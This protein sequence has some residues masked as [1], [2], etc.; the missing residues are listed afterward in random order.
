MKQPREST[1]LKL[2]LK[3][4]KHDSKQKHLG[5]KI[6]QA[7]IKINVPFASEFKGMDYPLSSPHP[8]SKVLFFFMKMIFFFIYLGSPASCF[9]HL[10]A[11]SVYHT[12]F[13]HQISQDLKKTIVKHLLFLPVLFQETP[14]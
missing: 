9:L 13:A 2:H 12:G 3:P 4:H 7:H 8:D 10:E 14:F 1:P 6:L 11:S 5:K